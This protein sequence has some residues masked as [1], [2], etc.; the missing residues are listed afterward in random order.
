MSPCEADGCDGLVDVGWHLDGE[1]SVC[2]NCGRKYR[3]WGTES[4]DPETDAVDESWV[5][6]APDEPNPWA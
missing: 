3:V 2:P 1:I 6:A 5:L 4:Y